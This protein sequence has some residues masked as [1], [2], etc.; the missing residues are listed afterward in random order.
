MRT[1]TTPGTLPEST[2]AVTGYKTCPAHREPPPSRKP[3][4]SEAI[5]VQNFS[6][7][8]PWIS[9]KINANHIVVRR[10]SN[11]PIGLIRSASDTIHEF[12][13]CICIHAGRDGSFRTRDQ[14][15]QVLRNHPRYHRQMFFMDATPGQKLLPVELRMEHQKWETVQLAATILEVSVASLC[16]EALHQR[17]MELAAQ[18]GG[19][20]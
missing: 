6:V 9:G 13:L 10:L 7:S 17:S 18:E 4:K 1:K 14:I 2:I 11:I 19:Q 12:A 16:R 20:A 3:K 5:A 15:L 8:T